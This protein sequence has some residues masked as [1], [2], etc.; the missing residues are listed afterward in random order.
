MVPSQKILDKYADVLINFALNNGKGVKPGEVVLLRVPECAKPLLKSLYKTVLLAKAHPII[1]YSPD[2][3]SRDLFEYGKEK[4]ISFF[5]KKYYKGLV[6]EADH[7]VAVLAET[8]K[9]ELEGIDSSLIM[10]RQTAFRPFMQ[11]REEKENKGKFSWTLGLYGTNAMA[12][13]ARLTL[14]E[15]WDQ[16]IKACFLDEKDPVAHWKKVTKEVDRLKDKLNSL[17]IDHL[18]VESKDTD[19]IIGL[20]KNRKWLGGGGHNIP[21]FEVFISPDF[22]RTQGKIRFNQPLYR[23]GNLIDEVYLEFKKGNVVKADAKKG[24]AVLKDMIKTKGANYVG[25]FS[26]TDRRLSNITKFMAETLYDENV[27]GRQGNTHIALGNAYKDSYPKNPIKVPKSKWKEMGYNESVIHTDIV[28]TYKRKVTA[29]LK[30]KKTLVIYEDG[31][32]KI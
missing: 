25:E 18:R 22:R 9:K 1:Q 11:W 26:L 31:E 7:L 2:E 17:D 15:Y 4:Q 23:Y 6:D 16:I 19:L 8:N 28:S 30:N 24:L 14:K 13:E 10:K 12:K 21:S 32:F 27:G 29:T 5:P 3:M 20:D